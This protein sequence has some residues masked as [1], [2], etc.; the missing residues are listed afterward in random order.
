MRVSSDYITA[1]IPTF[2]R[3]KPGFP[4]QCST[5]SCIRP[6]CAGQ[7]I[8]PSKRAGKHR[9]SRNGPAN[10][11]EMEVKMRNIHVAV[12]LAPLVAV[13]MCTAAVAD[14][15]YDQGTILGACDGAANCGYTKN[16]AGDASGCW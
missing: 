2:L 7:H 13:F 1:T 11:S 4:R 16:K 10:Q 12:L 14:K 15:T 5:I 8:G 6:L 9:T 3:S